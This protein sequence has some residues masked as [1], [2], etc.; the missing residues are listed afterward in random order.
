MAVSF[1]KY[2]RI[3]KNLKWRENPTGKIDSLACAR[4][5]LDKYEETGNSEFLMDAANFCMMQFTCPR[6]NDFFTATDSDGSP[7]LTTVDGEVVHST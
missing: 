2:G 7:G 3:R 5:R 4:Q 1:H 6:D